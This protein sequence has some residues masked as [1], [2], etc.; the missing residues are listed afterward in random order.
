VNIPAEV[1]ERFAQ[2]TLVSAIAQDAVNG[3]VLMLAW[4]NEEALT[5]TLESGW[6]TYWSRSREALWTKGQSSGH[7]QKLISVA[8]DC[9]GDALLLQV[10]QHGA[11]CHT[12]SRSCFFREIEPAP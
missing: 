5:K 4:M 8:Y 6:V 3:E 12:G 11:A 10:E 1:A 7:R 2:G 9:D